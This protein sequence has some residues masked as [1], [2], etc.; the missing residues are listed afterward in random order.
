MYARTVRWNAHRVA[1]VWA[2]W[3]STGGSLAVGGLEGEIG[4]DRVERQPGTYQALTTLV[5]AVPLHRGGLNEPESPETAPACDNH[6]QYYIQHHC[7]MCMYT[8]C[9]SLSYSSQL[10]LD[11]YLSWQQLPP[12]YYMYPYLRTRM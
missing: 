3:A 10:Y 12:I 5:Q 1:A 6:H 2:S 8:Y 7:T 9:I 4:R 11:I